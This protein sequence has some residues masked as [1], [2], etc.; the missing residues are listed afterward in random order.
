MRVPP[1]SDSV[2]V[3]FVG[4][5]VG[6]VGLS[7]LLGLIVWRMTRSSRELRTVW[8]LTAIFRLAA[9]SFVITEIVLGRFDPAW[10]SVPCIDLFWAGIQLTILTRSF[11]KR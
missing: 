2:W 10:I 5:F 8:G 6:C 7:Y 4:V 11:P 9:A 1:V 3:Q